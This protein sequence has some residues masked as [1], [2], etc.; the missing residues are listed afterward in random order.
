MHAVPLRIE[1]DEPDKVYTNLDFVKGRVILTV[2]DRFLLDVV[3]V[4]LIGVSETKLHKGNPE[5]KETHWILKEVQKIA[6]SMT[7]VVGEVEQVFDFKFQFPLYTQ[8]E[9]KKFPHK[10]TPLPSTSTHSLPEITSGINY[11]VKVFV[12]GYNIECE[13]SLRLNFST[14]DQVDDPRPLTLT[15]NSMLLL[16]NYAHMKTQQIDRHSNIFTKMFKSKRK[17]STQSF[18]D[19]QFHMMADFSSQYFTINHT[20]E[21]FSIK[22]VA[23]RDPENFSEGGTLLVESLI[24]KLRETT[25]LKVNK[26]SKFKTTEHNLLELH[27]IRTELANLA[28]SERGTSQNPLYELSLIPYNE[29]ISKH[30]NMSSSNFQQISPSFQACNASKSHSLNIHITFRMEFQNNTPA[31]IMKLPSCV[32]QL[33]T[34]IKVLGGQN[35]PNYVHRIDSHNSSL[36]STITPSLSVKKHEKSFIAKLEPNY[37]LPADVSKLVDQRINLYT[38][39]EV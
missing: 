34:P 39:N 4:K 3:R 30:F 21:P 2:K 12:K 25:E 31:K 5:D 32:C 37:R 10:Q 19:V 38:Q 15:S 24:I 26:T 35:P 17:H 14:F 20:P 23:N 27:N 1:L 18:Q 8:C 33:S 6:P 29:T 28:K 13:D 36:T 9:G 11:Y 7:P 22:L 16:Q